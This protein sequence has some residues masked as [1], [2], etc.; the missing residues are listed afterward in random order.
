MA[1]RRFKYL[2][3]NIMILIP[4]SSRHPDGWGWKSGTFGFVTS[5]RTSPEYLSNKHRWSF[6]HRISPKLK[7]KV[8]GSKS[9]TTASVCEGSE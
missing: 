2:N 6:L 3:L 5:F 1:L 4:D 9:C 8:F 7:Q